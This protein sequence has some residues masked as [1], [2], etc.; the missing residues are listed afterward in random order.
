M[1]VASIYAACREL[2]L[3]RTLDEIAEIANADSIF[4]GK[5]YRLLM[6]HLKLHFPVLDANAYLAKIVNKAHVSEMAYR[7]AL[8]MLSVVK[9]NPVSYG[10]DPKALAVAAL[11][12]ACLEEGEKV[13]QTQ[14]AVAGDTSIV[15][16]RKRFQDVRRI[17]P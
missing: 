10:K 14:I 8:Q 1:V 7:R 16:L 4:V 12:A 3:P 13:S 11:Y 5:C 2:N 17:F 15:T 6:R 9:D